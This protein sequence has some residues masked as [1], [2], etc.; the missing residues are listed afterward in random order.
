MLGQGNLGRGKTDGVDREGKVR[1]E[2]GPEE[3]EKDHVHLGHNGQY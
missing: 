2:K 3:E 1:R